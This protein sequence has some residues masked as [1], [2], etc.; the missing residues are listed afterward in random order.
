MSFGFS[1]APG[2]TYPEFLAHKHT[3]SDVGAL[4]PG[5]IKAGDG[6]SV[7]V[8]GSNVTISICFGA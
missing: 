4:A 2:V 5:N 8:S 6:I 1:N 3:A 7:S